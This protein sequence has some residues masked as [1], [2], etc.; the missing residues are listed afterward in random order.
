M[1]VAGAAALA[2]AATAQRFHRD[3]ITFAPRA[4]LRRCR[5]DGAADLVSGA[6]G[7]RALVTGVPVEVASADPAARDPDDDLARGG[8]AVGEVDDVDLPGA[9]Y[10]NVPAHGAV[11]VR[12]PPPS[13][14]VRVNVPIS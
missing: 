10:L 12:E 7:G 8:I 3:A 1:V 13:K 2:L 6:N 9:A 4:R 5:L 14:P 11:L